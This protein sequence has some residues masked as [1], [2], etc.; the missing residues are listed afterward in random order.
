MSILAIS[1]ANNVGALKESGESYRRRGGRR[2]GH[3]SQTNKSPVNSKEARGPGNAA[4]LSTK[5]FQ[6]SAGMHHQSN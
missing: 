2:S 3:Q 5:K 6:A 1:Q 4:C